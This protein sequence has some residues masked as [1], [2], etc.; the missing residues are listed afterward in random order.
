MLVSTSFIDEIGYYLVPT[1]GI[2]LDVLRKERGMV[3]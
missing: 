2:D 1:E 3:H